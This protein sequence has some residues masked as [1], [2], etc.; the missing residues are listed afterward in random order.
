MLTLRSTYKPLAFMASWAMEGQDQQ[1][2]R[3]WANAMMTHYVKKKFKVEG[4]KGRVKKYGKL[5]TFCG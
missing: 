2:N 3:N 4:T 5:S 1:V